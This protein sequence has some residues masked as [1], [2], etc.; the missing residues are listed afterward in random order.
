MW[1]GLQSNFP[2]AD[3][4]DL[5]DS[6]GQVMNLEAK[7]HSTAPASSVLAERQYYVALRVHRDDEPGSR[8]YVS[9]L[10]NYSQ[11]HPELTE[12]LKKLS[13]HDKEPEKRI[14]RQTQRSKNISLSNKKKL[15]K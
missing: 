11:S 4:V 10:N 5:M 3:F 13:N 7:Q 12:L 9:L 1:S 6:R 8:K 2:P 14:R 15:T